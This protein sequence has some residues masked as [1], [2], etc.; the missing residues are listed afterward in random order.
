V[1]L[2][3]A[4][5]APAEWALAE[6]LVADKY[7]TEAWTVLGRIPDAVGSAG[8]LA[9]P[10][11]GSAPTASAGLGTER[12]VMKQLPSIGRRAP[13]AARRRREEA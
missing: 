10:R 2:Q 7:G 9:R 12:A 5:L 4:S 3:P 1:P 6:A 13:D 11:P 8:V